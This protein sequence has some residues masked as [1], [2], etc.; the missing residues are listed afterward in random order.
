MLNSQELTPIIEFYCSGNIPG[1][2]VQKGELLC[3]YMLPFPARGSGYCRYVFILYKQDK[4]MDYSD[5]RIATPCTNLTA[6]TFSTY[7]FYKSL[8]DNITPTGLAFFESTWDHSLTPFF[9]DVLGRVRAR[10]FMDFHHL[11]N[12]PNFSPIGIPEP[13]VEYDFPAVELPPQK[14]FPHKKPFNLYLD[15]YKEPK[16]LQKELLVEKLKERHPFKPAPIPPRF[17]LAYDI[18]CRLPTW[19]KEDI[20]RRRMKEG[21]YKFM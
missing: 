1:N 21:K 9:Q 7:D 17:P 12:F 20:K 15:R 4:K 11:S 16:Q 5:Y 13:V 8:Q 10:V 14:W 3:D 6:R 2:D 19:L 18:N